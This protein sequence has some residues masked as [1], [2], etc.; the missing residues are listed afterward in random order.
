MIQQ[1][2]LKFIYLLARVLSTNNI[3]KFDV[4]SQHTKHPFEV[5]TNTSVKTGWANY[6]VS[7]LSLN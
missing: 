3:M 5:Y 4:L 7:V 6:R 2:L 1:I